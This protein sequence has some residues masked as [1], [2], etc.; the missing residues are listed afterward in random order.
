[1]L[2]LFAKKNF[3]FPLIGNKASEKRKE[4][5]KSYFSFY[6]IAILF[7]LTDAVFPFAGGLRFLLH[8]SGSTVLYPSIYIV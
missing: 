5:V 7:L 3:V 2:P 1:V 6:N 4:N 8:C